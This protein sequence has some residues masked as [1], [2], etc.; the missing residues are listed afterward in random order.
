MQPSPLPPPKKPLRG[1]DLVIVAG[2]AGCGEDLASV[3]RAVVEQGVGRLAL[4]IDTALHFF[5]L[6][7]I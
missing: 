3:P 5:F 7:W 2:R 1:F 6:N 4:E